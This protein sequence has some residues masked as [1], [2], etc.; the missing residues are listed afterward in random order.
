MTLPP[1]PDGFRWGVATAGHQNEG[2]NTTSDTWFL[3]NVQP[4]IFAERSG[5]AC[6]T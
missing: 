3:E 1:F 6:T 5:K 2:D 4:T